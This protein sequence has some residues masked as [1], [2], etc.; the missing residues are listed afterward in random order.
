ME[1]VTVILWVLKLCFQ[2]AGERSSVRCEHGRRQRE[3]IVSLSITRAAGGLPARARPCDSV[4]RE[5]AVRALAAGGAAGASFLPAAPASLPASSGLLVTQSP[6]Q[7]PLGAVGVINSQEGPPQH[8]HRVPTS[9][10]M[11]LT[12]SRHHGFPSLS[13]AEAWA[14]FPLCCVR[15]ACCVAGRH[16][17]SANPPSFCQGRLL[18]RRHASA[19]CAFSPSDGQSWTVT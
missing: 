18:P 10:D 6:W 16:P 17:A 8:G 12:P 2:R 4:N 11:A 19:P 13:P 5:P 9:D 14:S 15:P 3:R 1:A 7:G